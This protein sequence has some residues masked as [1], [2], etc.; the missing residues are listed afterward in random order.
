LAEHKRDNKRVNPNYRQVA[1]YV[2]LEVTLRFKSAYAAQGMDQN[3][4][5][6]EAIRLWLSMKENKTGVLARDEV[7]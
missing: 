3:E 7:S 4:A 6:E 1:G 5:V 2:P